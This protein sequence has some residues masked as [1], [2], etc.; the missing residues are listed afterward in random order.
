MPGKLA[1]IQARSKLALMSL[2]RRRR[3]KILVLNRS[4]HGSLRAPVSASRAGPR[5]SSRPSPGLRYCL[6][7][8]CSKAPTL[9][10]LK[11]SKT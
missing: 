10:G 4:V 5:N 11:G 2:I 8:K 1:R 6:L 9:P 3:A 7:L